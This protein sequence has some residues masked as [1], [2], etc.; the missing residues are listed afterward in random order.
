MGGIVSLK[1]YRSQLGMAHTGWLLY[2]SKMTRVGVGR[3]GGDDDTQGE[4]CMC[5][6]Q[7]KVHKVLFRFDEGQT[8]KCT[9][10]GSVR[11]SVCK[12]GPEK[13][14]KKEMTCYK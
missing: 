4:K 9:C 12:D 5:M 1:M 10:F 14:Q 8:W 11:N 7:K 6:Y 13:E 3:G 2:G